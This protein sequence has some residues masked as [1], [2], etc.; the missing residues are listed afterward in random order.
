ML[1]LLKGLIAC[2]L[3]HRRSRGGRPQRI[4]VVDDFI[5]DPIIGSGTP[6]AHHL[7]RALAATGAAVTHISTL[8]RPDG[9][10]SV[11]PA[12]S[13]IRYLFSHS[14][15][16][17]EFS[18]FIR[19]RYRKFDVM[20]VSRRHNLVAINDVLSQDPKIASSV[21]LVFDSEAIFAAR[22]EL[23][24]EITGAR[25]EPGSFTVV[26][27]VRLAQIADLIIAVNEIDA[28]K[29]RATGRSDVTVLGHSVTPLFDPV[30]HAE[31][32]NFLFVGPAYRDET[33]NGDALI[34]FADQVIPLLR[35]TI[36]PGIRL[37]HVGVVMA[38]AIQARG[39]ST[40]TLRGPLPDLRNEFRNARVFVAPTRYASGIPLKVC[41][42]AAHGVPCVTTP[43]LAHQLGWTHNQ[44]ALVAETPDDFARES[45]KLFTDAELWQRI[46]TAAFA[47]VT[48][49]HSMDLF[50]ETVARIC[51]QLVVKTPRFTPTDPQPGLTSG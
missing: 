15:G 34:W 22:E 7:L 37:V 32:S 18:G 44:E 36:S 17:A 27:E 5:P 9:K 31:R 1:V 26:E 50:D 42:A 33:P 29:F 13:S 6:R 41:E 39:G 21:K 24:R 51:A 38:P 48:R 11:K 46:R 25:P 40:L 8:P 35:A 16:A 12:L 45:L 20:V 19:R 14:A 2:F 23:H 10:R 3:K 47:A 49:A 4:L 43:L 28:E 30:P